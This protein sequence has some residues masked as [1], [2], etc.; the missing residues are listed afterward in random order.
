MQKVRKILIAVVEEIHKIYWK[1]VAQNI[2]HKKFELVKS[3]VT[4]TFSLDE[5]FRRT[6]FSSI[7]S[8]EFQVYVM[9]I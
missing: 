6:K 4:E 8:K 2:Y 1:F 9:N 7:F 5:T 3:L